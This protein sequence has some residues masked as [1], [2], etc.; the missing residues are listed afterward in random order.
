MGREIERKFLVTGDAWRKDA[1]GKRYRQGYLSLEPKRTVRVRSDG[2]KGAITIKGLS[3]GASRD[4]FEYP[5]PVKDANDLLKLCERPLIEKTR[6]VVRHGGLT[7]EIDVFE[8]ANR[9]L[10]IAEVELRSE[11]QRV[12]LPA[13]V[14][15]EVTHD[16][17]YFNANLVK[18][19]FSRW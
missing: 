1:K 13:W 14:G 17:R 4:E 3:R 12:A 19:P 11:K 10:R 16:A 18:H 15:S 5:I 6:F 8:G 2:R 7:W 9:G